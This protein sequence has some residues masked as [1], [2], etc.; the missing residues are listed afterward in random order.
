MKEKYKQ[1]Y[2]KTKSSIVADAAIPKVGY[3]IDSYN[4]LNA[5]ELI[6]LFKVGTGTFD[7]E[8]TRNN[9]KFCQKCNHWIKAD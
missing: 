9:E 6:H 3:S 7:K 5:R 8:T 1:I 2:N 4:T